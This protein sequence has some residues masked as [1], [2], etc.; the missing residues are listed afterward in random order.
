MANVSD[1]TGSLA[2]LRTLLCMFVSVILNVSNLILHE[3]LHY[4]IIHLQT[5]AGTQYHHSVIDIDRLC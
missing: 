3:L 2:H 1:L 5:C 4:A